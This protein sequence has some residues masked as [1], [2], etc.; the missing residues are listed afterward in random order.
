MNPL[1]TDI[2]LAFSR[3]VCPSV[4]E[5]LHP[6]SRDYSDLEPLL[7]FTDWRSIP[8]EVIERS[9]FALP[10]TSAKAYVFVLPAYLKWVLKYARV[11]H[12]IVTD[13]T[14]YSLNPLRKKGELDTL[15]ESHY[16]LITE[17]QGATIIRW[18]EYL[19]EHLV[20]YIDAPEAETA[21][22]YWRSRKYE[23]PVKRHRS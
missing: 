18:L 11:N 9:Q 12:S 19:L 20:G 1:P 22:K 13:F 15:K 6:A 3:T 21:L 7:P 10:F 17:A 8:A 16:A 23:M 2:S 14:I 5:W 4:K